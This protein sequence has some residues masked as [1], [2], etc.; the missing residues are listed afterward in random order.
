M[1]YFN[2]KSS[3]LNGSPRSLF[4]GESAGVRAGPPSVAL[5]LQRICCFQ[6]TRNVWTY[7][8]YTYVAR[9]FLSEIFDSLKQTPTE[10]KWC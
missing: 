9:S 7:F 3:S 8:S 6:T 5:Y 2:R 4:V 10:E 1:L